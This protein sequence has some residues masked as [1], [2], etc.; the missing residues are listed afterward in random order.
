MPF[1]KH[2]VLG[3][4]TQ[5][6]APEDPELI[7]RGITMCKAKEMAG[8]GGMQTA[9]ANWNNSGQ[10][11]EGV[12]RD[13]TS[14]GPAET[15]GTLCPAAAR[16]ASPGDAPGKALRGGSNVLGNHRCTAVPAT[17]ALLQS[18]GMERRGRDRQGR[19]L[20]AAGEQHP[21]SSTETANG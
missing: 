21:A 9:Q 13:S 15:P 19:R 10:T 7:G 14:S 4:S 12:Q 1:G 17:P 16:A 11:E 5:E 8:A 20:L 6:R 2:G 3:K 18:S